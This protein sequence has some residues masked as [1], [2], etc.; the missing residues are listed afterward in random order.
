[1]S[2]KPLQFSNLNLIFPHKTCFADA[3]VRVQHGQRVAV[4]G[5]NGSGKSS[6]LQMLVERLATD[7]A[8]R[9]GYVAQIPIEN[10]NLSGG[11]AFNRSLTTAL[12]SLPN[13]LVLDEP[14][15]HLD[16]RNRSSLMRLLNGWRDTLIVATHDED[17]LKERFDTIW[18][19][20]DGQLRIFQG[21]HED[22]VTTREQARAAVLDE[23]KHITK[24]KKK[25]HEA[26]M[27]E[28][29][30]AKGSRLIG[31][32]NVE[33]KKWPTIVS[34]AKARRAENTTGK[35]KVEL[36]QER[37]IML[38]RLSELKQSEIITP[39][40]YFR[41]KD[42]GS[43]LVSLRDASIGFEKTLIH[44]INI[45]VRFGERIA[46]L[47]DNGSGKSTLIKAVMNSEGIIRGGEWQV[48][49]RADIGVLDQNYRNL[50]EAKTVWQMLLELRPDWQAG[51][52]RNHLNAFL[53]RKNDE[54]MAQINVLSGGERARLSLCLIAAR[55]PRL[56]LL[57]E[58]TN[59]I[60]SETRNHLVSALKNY[61]GAMIIISHDRDF[62][63]KMQIGRA[64][65]V[66]DGRLE[67]T[68]IS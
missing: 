54:V 3:H 34:G 35:K 5:K 37:E 58:I 45:C 19:L 31:E 4:I 25:T 43:V 52:L 16:A 41:A 27:K 48:I 33:R 14:T 62:L 68:V 55:A 24:E 30:R 11:E 26:L 65:C 59:N 57:D 61:E 60:D 64:L 9:V 15:N 67:E 22:Y 44:N 32:K 23:L 46:L 18:H 36:R 56:L 7:V 17:L 47:G 21:R 8:I 51:E 29:V 1:M 66:S 63:S 40:F 20:D 13:V 53:F 6:L 2:H 50:D 49:S 12:S 10:G 42:K 38:E 28:Q 39:K